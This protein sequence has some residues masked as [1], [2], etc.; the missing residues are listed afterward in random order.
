[1]NKGYRFA[2]DVEVNAVTIVSASGQSFNIKDMVLEINIYQ[3]IMSHYL[4][5]DIAIEDAINLG[6]AVK[7]NVEN[8]IPDGFNGSELLIVS[9]RER[10]DASLDS[11][12]PFK[13]HI[14]G[15]YETSDRSRMNENTESYIISG[16]SMEAYQ[17]IPQKINK[18][19]GRDGGNTISNMM[20][21]V[22]NEYVLSN[23][24]KDI[25]REARMSKSFICDETSGL[26]KYIIPSLS[27]DETIDFFTKEADAEDHYPYFIFY[28]DS[29]GFNFRNVPTMIID[30]PIDWTYK[31]FMSNVSDSNTEEGVED[32]DQY[33]I[34]SYSI[35]K[36]ENILENVK[37]GLFKSKTINLDILKKKTNVSNFDYNKES[38]N[39]TTTS[40]GKFNVEVKGDPIINLTTSRTGHDSDVL[41]SKEMPFPKK[42]NTFFNKKNSYQKQLF[43]KVIEISIPG[44]TTI[45]VGGV[46]DLNFFIH[47]DI[48]T[49]KGQ[50]DKLLSGSYLITKVRQKITNEVFTT[51]LECS[52]GTNLL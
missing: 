4:Q 18:A 30:A 8:S 25:Y 3:S 27:V 29:K 28:E 7:G 20:K 44:N 10:T 36:D 13:K 39:F 24:I 49:D 52:K 6:N 22:V 43:N 33:K 19:Y 1:M 16:I 38:D 51:L 31:Y 48:E 14:F 21:S 15:I 46:I 50:L 12:I 42:V 41:F 32:D 17:T 35:L 47:N 11:K 23:S 37:G 26:Q 45:N 9:Y 34:I 40:N 5:C 2:G